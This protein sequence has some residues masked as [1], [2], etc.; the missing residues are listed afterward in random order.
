MSDKPLESS[1]DSNASISVR[2]LKEPFSEPG[3]K[4]SKERGPSTFDEKIEA[5]IQE[6]PLS[7]SKKYKQAMSGRSLIATVNAF[8]TDTSG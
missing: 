7:C 3:D 6:I 5:R 4:N 8:C 1:C 2:P